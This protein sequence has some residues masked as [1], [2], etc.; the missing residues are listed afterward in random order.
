MAV[1]LGGAAVLAGTLCADSHGVNPGVKESIDDE[2]TTS[3]TASDWQP[4]GGA[5]GRQTAIERSY[6]ISP[7]RAPRCRAHH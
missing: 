5:G 4:D 6:R 3:D 7:D 1:A 2:Q